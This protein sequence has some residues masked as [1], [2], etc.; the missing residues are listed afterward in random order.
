MPKNATNR[1][2]TAV[3]YRDAKNN[4][5]VASWVF[6]LTGNPV[7][8]FIGQAETFTNLVGVA[9]ENDYTCRT[10][11]GFAIRNN[12]NLYY[13]YAYVYAGIGCPAP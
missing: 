10:I 3:K 1:D 5:G 12:N 2:L 9:T 6:Q 7:N 13:E 8:R 4:G 11:H